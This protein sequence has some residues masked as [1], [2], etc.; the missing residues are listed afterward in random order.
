MR[1]L[2]DNLVA[3]AVIAGMAFVAFG[4]SYVLFWGFMNHNP[5]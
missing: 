4:I 3:L 1:S 5:A 2:I